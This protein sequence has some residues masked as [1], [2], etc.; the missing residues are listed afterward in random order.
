MGVKM[1]RLKIEAEISSDTLHA[2]EHACGIMNADPLAPKRKDGMP[3]TPQTLAGLHLDESL[4]F[5]ATFKP[6]SPEV[7]RA[8]LTLVGAQSDEALD[9]DA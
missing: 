6:I 8:K 1:Y 5:F 9:R 3:W 7:R 4:N 2:M